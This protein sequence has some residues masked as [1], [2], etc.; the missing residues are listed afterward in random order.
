MAILPDVLAGIDPVTPAH[1]LESVKILPDWGQNEPDLYGHIT[2]SAISRAE[3]QAPAR[4]RVFC[5]AVTAEGN[6]WRGRPS[7]WSAK[8]D[9]LTYGDGSDQ[10]LVVISAGNIDAGYLAAEYLDQNDAA[11]VERVRLRHGTP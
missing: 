5:M 8:V 2:A 3:V 11:G 6:H 7:S 10:R 4:S 9:D 1:R